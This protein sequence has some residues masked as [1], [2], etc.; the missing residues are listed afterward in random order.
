MKDTK[1]IAAFDACG[2]TYEAIN[3][4]E[5]NIINISYGKFLLIQREWTAKELENIRIEWDSEPHLLS[6]ELKVN[7]LKNELRP[8]KNPKALEDF[9]TEIKK[10]IGIADIIFVDAS[11][12][13]RL[14]LQSA[15]IDY[16]LIYPDETLKEEW[17]GRRFLRGDSDYLCK[18]FASN[19]DKN[20]EA[21]KADTF[22]NHRET[23]VLQ[24]GQYIADIEAYQNILENICL[25]KNE[26]QEIEL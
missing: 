21:L 20:I 13:A 18:M 24:H 17:V 23:Y 6:G 16:I 11:Q 14:A 9:I 10:N 5:K 26:I 19:W 4:E 7:R 2:K 25:H 1:I 22:K 8:D 15:G 12:N 3:K